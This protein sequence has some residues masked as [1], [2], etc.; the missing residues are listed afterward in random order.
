MLPFEW[1]LLL[2]FGSCAAVE[3]RTSGCWRMEWNRPTNWLPWLACLMSNFCR[4]SLL[5]KY[6]YF[7]P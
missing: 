4:E 2:L 1:R 5:N 3:P 6:E 7:V